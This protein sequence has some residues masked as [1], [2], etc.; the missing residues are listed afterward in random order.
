MPLLMPEG[1]LMSASTMKGHKQKV[2]YY[3]PMWVL[4]GLK[5]ERTQTNKQTIKLKVPGREHATDIGMRKK[6]RM[7]GTIVWVE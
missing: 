2:I 1:R 5:N 7:H 3:E 4:M 6:K